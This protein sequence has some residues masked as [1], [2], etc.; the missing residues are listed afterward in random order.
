MD[1]QKCG[2][3][4]TLLRKEQGIT[5]KQLAEQIGVTDKAISRWETGKGLPDASSL[6]ALSER[7][8]VTI[9]ELLRGE[10]T[11]ASE[12]IEQIA[13]ENVVGVLKM[14]DGEKKK[15]RRLRVAVVVSIVCVAAILIAV[16]GGAVIAE[17]RGDGYSLSARYYTRMAQG[18][19][20]D[21]KDGHYERA[22]KH[23]GFILRDREKAQAK[24][25]DNVTALFST[26][27]KIES[28]EVFPMEEDDEFISGKAH[29]K[30]T[31][32][33]TSQRYIYSMVVN[34]QD[35]IAFAGIH[36]VRTGDADDA[37]ASRVEEIRHLLMKALSTYYPG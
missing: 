32:L 16:F 20:D 23:I 29:I 9:N 21:I 5:Q 11:T 2:A 1:I 25:I 27:L 4:I 19:A 10:R 22:V 31:D 33:Q 15:S 13:E 30:I 17:I 7:F 36:P 3:F 6:L 34:Q 35:G 12:T 37:S 24:W 28:F 8:G 26:E 18:V 14:H